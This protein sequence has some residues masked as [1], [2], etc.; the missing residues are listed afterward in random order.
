MTENLRRA[1][2]DLVVGEPP[3]R[4]AATDTVAS[5]RRRQGRQR[6][7]KPDRL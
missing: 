5:G 7:P 1:F 4:M 3:V 6:W 2:D